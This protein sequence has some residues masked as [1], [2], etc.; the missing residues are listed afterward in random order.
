MGGEKVKCSLIFKEGDEVQGFTVKNVIGFGSFG[1]VYEVFNSANNQPAAMKVEL[2]AQR[3]HALKNELMILRKLRNANVRHI[4]KVLPT[5]ELPNIHILSCHWLVPTS[6]LQD[7]HSAGYLHR[8]VKPENFAIGNEP[9]SRQLFILDFGMSRQFVNNEHVHRKPR[10]K[11]GFRGTLFYA[12]VNALKL[13][14]Q[15]RKDDIWSW[16]YMLIRMTTGNLPWCHKMPSKEMKLQKQARALSIF[17]NEVMDNASS[18]LAG[19]PTEFHNFLR[20]LKSLT[21]YDRPD[22]EFIYSQL[23]QI[24]KKNKLT[25]DMPLDWEQRQPKRMH[26]IP[27]N[28][29]GNTF[30]D[31]RLADYADASLTSHKAKR[32]TKKLRDSHALRSKYNCWSECHFEICIKKLPKSDNDSHIYNTYPVHLWAII[33]SYIYPEDICRFALICSDAASAIRSAHFWKLL[34]NRRCK[35]IYSLPEEY[36]PISMQRLYGLRAAVIRS[37]FF[38]YEPFVVRMKTM[39]GFSLSDKDIRLLTRSICTSAWHRR[40]EECSEQ[41]KKIT[42][43]SKKTTTKHANDRLKFMDDVNANKDDGC[44]VL[45]ASANAFTYINPAVLGARLGQLSTSL[46][47]D[48]N[49]Y[50]I[51]LTFVDSLTACK[52]KRFGATFSS[53]GEVVQLTGVISLSVLH[54]WYPMEEK[55]KKEELWRLSISTN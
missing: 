1:Q 47:P 4:C 5:E 30:G 20:H 31:V 52:N 10:A 13:C 2:T 39:K 6:A 21:Y 7:M 27:G 44:F 11:C 33:A 54:W 12:S 50:Q 43:V 32:L 9:N 45:K 8:D 40:I 24:M 14:E 49:T 18:F 26:M 17:K 37:L 28:V 55:K 19:C 25:D 15:S 3:N 38:A 22:Y 35:D 51:C 16:F 41:A 42:N 36:K 53:A 29:V 34:Y 23:N 46:D 48:T